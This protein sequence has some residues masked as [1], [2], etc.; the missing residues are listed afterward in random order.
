MKRS[1]SIVATLVLTGTFLASGTADAQLLVSA[2]DAKVKLVDG[3]NTTV[4][5]APPDTVTIINLGATPPKIVGE[6]NAP[7]SVVGPPQ[8]VAIAPDESIALVTS[9]NRIDPADPAKVV[10]DDRLTVIDLRASP[11]AVLATLHAGAGASGVSINRAG[12]LALVANRGEGS[13]SVFT[14]SGKTVAA[15]GKVTLGAPDCGPSG[16][17]FSADGKLALVTRNNDN[18]VAVLAIDGSRVEYGGRTIEAGLKPYGIEVT[19]K[20]DVA[21]VGNIGAGPT[22]APDTVS[23]I[24]LAANTPRA[25]AHVTVG[26]TVEGV[27]ISPDGRYVAVTVMNGSNNPKSSPHFHEFGLVR[28][29]SLANT[30]LTPVA[31]AKVGQWCQGVAWGPASRTV[32]VQCMVER[33]IETFTFDEKQLKAGAPIKVNGGPAGIRTAQR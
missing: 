21:I 11:P 5:N 23:V 17:A 30:T 33:Q 10:P 7:N 32:L 31:D 3:V 6:V 12:T 1:S 28:V 4:P 19:P 8:N 16:I 13:V 24:D 14:I 18:L 20:G 29:F 26:P 15:D 22:G 9:S 25:V 27:S 2:N